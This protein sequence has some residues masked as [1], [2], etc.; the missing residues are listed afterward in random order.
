MRFFWAK[1]IWHKNKNKWVYT[2]HVCVHLLKKKRRGDFLKIGWRKNS[3]LQKFPLLQCMLFYTRW[4]MLCH[5]SNVLLDLVK[6]PGT[7]TD[8]NTYKQNNQH[9]LW[10]AR[11]WN[12]NW[13]NVDIKYMI[14]NVNHYV[15]SNGLENWATTHKDSRQ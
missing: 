12:S 14:A 2:M 5:D 13:F 8:M 7:K 9:S 6:L 15:V 10:F 1:L 3:Q 4:N 11:F